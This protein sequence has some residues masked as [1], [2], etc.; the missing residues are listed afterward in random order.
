MPAGPGR[1]STANA[2]A[3][4]QGS[5]YLLSGIWPLLHMRSFE[6]VTGPKTDHWLVRTVSGLL[7]TNGV[8]LLRFRTTPQELRVASSIGIGTAATLAAIDVTHAAR[9]RI[10]KVYLLDVRWTGSSQIHT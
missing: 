6:A 2:L 5:L 7:I 1:K 9:G 8:A 4:V 3:I 10:S